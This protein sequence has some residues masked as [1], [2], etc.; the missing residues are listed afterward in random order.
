MQHATD[1]LVLPPHT[2]HVLQ[3]L[4]LSNFAPVKRALAAETYLAARLDSGLMQR[5]EWTEMYIRAREEALTA[6]NIVKG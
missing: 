1:L 6:A 4:D 5:V 3:P 2:S